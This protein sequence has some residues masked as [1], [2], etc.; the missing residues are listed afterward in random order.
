MTKQY[1]E[2]GMQKSVQNMGVGDT[3]VTKP[4]IITKTDLELYAICTGDTHPLFLSEEA[5]KAAGWENQLVP[6]LLTFSIAH[7]LL[8]QAGFTKDV[9][10][11]MG[12][13]NLRFNATVYAYATIRVETEVLS[14]RQT[15]Q[16]R[17]V[18]TYSWVVKNQNDQVVA[19]G[20]NHWMLRA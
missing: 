16:G 7:G 11:L 12:T 6:G 19:E 1:A 8:T 18:G 17:W 10:A 14:K 2:Q 20:E 15:S 13:D 3:F 9:M 5:A 4:R